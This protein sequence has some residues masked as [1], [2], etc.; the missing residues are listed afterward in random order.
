VGAAGGLGTPEALA[1]AFAMG[2]AYVLTG[3]V[4]QAA[5]ESGLSAAGRRMLAGAGIADVT[6]APSPDMFELGVKV[7]VLRRGTLFSQR[8]ARLYELYMSHESLE[9]MT[10]A[11]RDKLEREIFKAPVAEI[12][13]QTRSFFA[14]RSPA[15]IQRA[16]ASPKH[17]MGLVFRWYLGK[18]S[19]WAIDG[20]A[21]R[22]LDYQIWCG[23]AQGAFNAWA[24][25]TFMEPP[26]GRSV[27]QIALNLLE[28]AAVAARAQQ[29]RSYG[30]PV[31]SAAFCFAPRPLA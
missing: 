1:A 22:E 23:P 13:E 4:N 11:V 31:P 17:R 3:S 26:E 24:R 28:G 15:E 12:W 2:A 5:V 16:E 19:R 21:G 27:V 7:Q 29:V 6:M 10:P 8:A 25:G 30:V 18:A 9:A 14:R 20:E